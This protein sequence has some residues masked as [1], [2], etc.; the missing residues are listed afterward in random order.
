MNEGAIPGARLET[1]ETSVT[2]NDYPNTN[3]S[4]Q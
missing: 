4:Y 1:N 3:G 2:P